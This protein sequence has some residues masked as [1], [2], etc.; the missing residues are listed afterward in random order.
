MDRG[1]GAAFGGLP[2][3]ILLPWMS[4]VPTQS[5]LPGLWD[6]RDSTS[7]HLQHPQDVLG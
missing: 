5:E 4:E 2:P 6:S 3:A 1:I 7:G